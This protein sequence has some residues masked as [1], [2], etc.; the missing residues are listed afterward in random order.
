MT[1]IIIIFAAAFSF[2]F[3]STPL[4]R[5]LAIRSSFIAVP[6]ADRAHTEPTALMG[7]LAIYAAAIFALLSVT[8][9]VTILVGNVFRLR[10]FLTIIM[11]AS[12]MAAIGLWDDRKALPAWLKLALQFIPAVLVFFAGVQ[13]SLPL[14]YLPLPGE[15]LNF[16]ITVSWILF[17]TNAINY[18][19]NADGVAVMTSATTGAIFMLIAILNDQQLVSVLAAAVSAA[20]LGFARYNLPLPQS[21]IF[22]GDSGSLF[23]GYLIAILGIKIRIPPNDIQIT[24]MVPLIVLGLP[25]FDTILVFISRTRRGI[26]FFQGGVDHSTHRLARLGLDRLAVALTV[27]LINGALGLIAIFVTQVTVIEAYAIAGTLIGI[28]LYVLWHLEF[29]AS[30]QFRTGFALPSLDIQEESTKNSSV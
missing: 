25:I 19:D 23:L 4:I 6:K 5:H 16:F 17:I 30:Y 29:K 28:V 20:S 21:T 3:V 26:S 1:T 7:G 24:W 2:S 10:E 13:V 14:S 11:G 8:F 12:L 22:M 9:L 15:A 27:S 18:L